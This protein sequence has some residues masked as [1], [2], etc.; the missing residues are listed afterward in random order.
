M[1]NEH[2]LKQ[3]LIKL[4]N[5]SVQDQEKLLHEWVTKRVITLGEYKSLLL[6]IRHEKI[7]EIKTRVQH[8][9]I[10]TKTELQPFSTNDTESSAFHISELKAKLAANVDNT[11]FEG[12]NLFDVKTIIPYKN[13]KGEE[14]QWVATEV[15]L[16]EL[17][18]SKDMR[19]YDLIITY[20]V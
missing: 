15:D 11:S 2:A 20:K 6:T 13:N 9:Q 12:M 16:N 5:N 8:V 14:E 17:Y 3:K 19:I 4:R 1:I 10:T 7:M 18:I